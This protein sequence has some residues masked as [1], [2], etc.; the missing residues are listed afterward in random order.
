MDRRDCRISLLRIGYSQK[1]RRSRLDLRRPDPSQLFPTVSGLENF[2][3]EFLT[4]LEDQRL[5]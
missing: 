1:A 4:R 2:D 5:L 3:L